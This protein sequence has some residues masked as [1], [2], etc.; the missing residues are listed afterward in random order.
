[1]QLGLLDM[2]PRNI[3]LGVLLILFP[4]IIVISLDA[5]ILN[6]GMA[7][8]DLFS[9]AELRKYTG[10][11]LTPLN[12]LLAAIFYP[13]INQIFITGYT[14]NTLAKGN[15]SSQ[16][17]IG[18]G[19]LYSFM[20]FHMSLGLLALGIISAGLFRLTGSLLPAIMF[21]IGCASAKIL[22]LANYPRIIT[23]LVFLV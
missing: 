16:A 11:E 17:I 23:V 1:M 2:K 4:V 6:A 20:S 12:L 14:L 21:G 5:L 10:E 9:G 22:I 15:L 8:N 3:F 18:N 19:I 13:A 7:T